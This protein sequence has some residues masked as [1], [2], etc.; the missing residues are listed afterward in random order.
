MAEPID[1]SNF[2]EEMTN[3]GKLVEKEM[4]ERLYDNNSV[5]TGQLASSIQS[6]QVKET[7][8][9]IFDLP[10]SFAKYGI[11][12][13]NGAERGSGKMPPVR[14]IQEWIQFKRIS[15]PPGY[16]TQ[17]FAWAVAKTIAKKGQRFKKPKPWIEVSLNEVVNQ[18][19][20]ELGDAAAMDI[21]N[22]I[23]INYG[24]IG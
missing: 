23:E 21:D 8:A 15:V 14:A 6:E 16:T 11:Y 4:V 13:D 18:N 22:N 17:Q 10:I 12:V 9:D 19:L 7:S 2:V 1:Y 5:V 3:V 20:Q 24:E